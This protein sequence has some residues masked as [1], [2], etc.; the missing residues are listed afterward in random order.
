[1]QIN[2][3]V[4]TTLLILIST[5][6]SAQVGTSS[7]YSIAGIGELTYDGFIQHRAMGRTSV[8]QQS[9][10]LFSRANPASLANIRYTIF[11]VGAKSSI[12]RLKTS[13]QEAEISSGNFSY[14][15]MAFPIGDKKKMGVS[16][17]TNAVSDVGYEIRNR[18][19]TDTPSYY[20]VFNG[21]G[22]I[23]RV[24]L[25]YGL[26]LFKNFNIGLNINY[27]FGNITT[28]RLKVYPI[29]ESRYS[30]FDGTLLAYRGF[31]FDLG[32]QY[33][34]QDTI[35][36]N[37]AKQTIINHA[38]GGAFQSENRLSGSGFRY[39]ATFPGSV[40]ERLEA[41]PDNSVIDTV[42]FQD[43]KL[44]TLTKP[45]GFTVGYTVSNGEKWSLSLEME[46]NLWSTITDKVSGQKFY[47][48]SRYGF[49]F[50]FVPRPVYG[51]K[52]EFFK[53]V[54]YSIG[55]SYQDMYYNF[56]GTQL[57]ELGISFG[58]GIPVVKSIRIDGEKTAIVSRINLSAEYISRGTVSSGLIQEDYI[59]FGI[60][61]NLND[62]WF[63][64]RKYR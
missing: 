61:L 50:S 24:Y 11:D 45:I 23:S 54:R 15:V 17:G 27:D 59:N 12:G 32:V 9:L 4:W 13:E 51:E 48:N 62:K 38:F 2:S 1:M 34:V 43:D 29:S 63:T 64:K 47:N 20:N 55:A 8:S 7:P 46:Q 6:A 40:Y 31:D 28:E 30:F 22:G 44:D 58:L 16:F 41:I 25:G 49:G 18:F 52:G 39:A 60:G 19:N 53:K 5:F 57:T 26:E 37:S 42:I 14:F 10:N 35:R 56:N 21:S 3:K 33:A 36:F